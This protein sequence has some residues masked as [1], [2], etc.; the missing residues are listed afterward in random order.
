[1][2]EAVLHRLLEHAGFTA[3]PIYGKKGKHYLQTKVNAYNQAAHRLPWVI[4]VDLNHEADCAPLLRASWLP[5]PAPMMCFRVAIREIEAWLLADRERFSAFFSVAR[6]RIPQNAEATDNP[7]QTV[8]YLARHSRR[9]EIRE[10]M[11]PRPE[12]GREVGPAYNSRLIEFVTD[13]TAGWRPDVAV[14]HSESLR[15]CVQCLSRFSTT[16]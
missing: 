11:V 7:K 4:L 10:E 1:M 14:N 3:G 5:D 9:R 6:S 2:D 15:R 12:S 16:E 13:T 8:I